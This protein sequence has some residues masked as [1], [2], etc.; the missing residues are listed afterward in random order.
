MA[1]WIMK[2]VGQP[3]VKNLEHGIRTGVPILKAD[4]KGQPESWVPTKKLDGKLTGKLDQEAG[5]KAVQKPNRKAT[6]TA[7]WKAIPKTHCKSQPEKPTGKLGGEP[8][9]KLAGKEANRPIYWLPKTKVGPNM[10]RLCSG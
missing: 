4:Q 8:A 2:L 1:H 10:D 9:G 7:G 3:N 6:Q 5:W